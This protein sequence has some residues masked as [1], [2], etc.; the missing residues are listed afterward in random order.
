MS[1]RR[2]TDEE[3]N[4]FQ[5][6]L[7]GPGPVKGPAP[8][9]LKPPAAKKR[10]KP[11]LGGLDGHTADRLNRGQLVPDAK[12][13]LHGLTEAAAHRALTAFIH[14][15]Q[16]RGARL[17]LVVTGKGT[18]TTD[19]PFDPG[20]DGRRRGVLKAMVPRWLREPPIAGLIA[21]LRPAHLRHGGDGALYVYLHNRKKLEK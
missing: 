21:D 13:D 20:L 15:A 4:L 5:T 14:M 11:N 19:G 12:L 1:R 17:L 3:R 2:T 7:A 8:K 10:A 16:R 6:A 9:T 18:R